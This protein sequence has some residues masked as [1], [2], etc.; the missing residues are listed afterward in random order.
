MHAPHTDPRPNLDKLVLR[1]TLH[2]DVDLY[3]QQMSVREI[4]WKYEIAPASARKGL[5]RLLQQLV[6]WKGMDGDHESNYRK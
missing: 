1:S 2:L 4:L 6:Q 5:E 3:V